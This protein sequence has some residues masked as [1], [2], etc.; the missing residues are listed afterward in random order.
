MTRSRRYQC[1]MRNIV[2]ASLA[3]M[4]TVLFAPLTSVHAAD[5]FEPLFNGQNLDG[6]YTWDK[7]YKKN[8]DVENYFQVQNGELVI[9]DIPESKE[10]K[11]FGYISTND[12]YEN[13]HLRFEYQWGEKKYPPRDA[14]LRDSGVLYHMIG[15]D[16]LW[17]TS[18]ES[19]VQ[20]GDTGDFFGLGGASIESTR[21]GRNYS[22]T[23]DRVS[24]GNQRAS[25]IADTP[26]SYTHLTLPTIY[27]V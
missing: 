8:N 2:V 7:R 5:N 9:L 27:S 17:P 15:G 16:R 12:D 20:E 26:V 4:Q 14:L 22:P 25:S 13:Y 1:L 23:G 11:A 10:N 6:W 3:V 18:L 19:Q 21:N 24:G